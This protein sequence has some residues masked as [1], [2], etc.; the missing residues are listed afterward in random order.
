MAGM[1]VVG[2]S[3]PAT[4]S[5]ADGREATLAVANSS[6]TAPLVVKRSSTAVAVVVGHCGRFCGTAAAMW[7][8]TGRAS[9]TSVKPSPIRNDNP[10]ID[11]CT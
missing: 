2:D 11:Q 5:F 8:W 3:S 9:S 1:C 4:A 7:R 6:S 10:N